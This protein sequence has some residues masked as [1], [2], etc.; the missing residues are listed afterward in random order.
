MMI[1]MKRRVL[2]V[3]AACAFL[4]TLAQATVHTM[5]VTSD[6]QYPWTDATDRGIDEDESTKRTRSEA[7]ITEQYESIAAYRA[8]RADQRIPVVINGDLTAYGHG[9][10]RDTFKRLVQ[11]LG[12]DVY[13]G[14][15]NHDYQNNIRRENGEGCF[16]NACARGS[17]QDF[18]KWMRGQRMALRVLSFDY[19][20]YPGLFRDVYQGSLGY[21]F[22][23]PG[24][25]YALQAQLHNAPNYSVRFTS[26]EGIRAAE[27][28]IEAP[29]TYWL[30]N[31][32]ADRM[33]QA[34]VSF[35]VMHMH[36]PPVY[37]AAFVET[38]RQHPVSA[39]FAGH[40][41][42]WLGLYRMIEGVPVFLS[43]SASQRSYLI[44]E[45]DDQA[46]RL[47]VY[48]V[49]NNDPEHAELAYEGEAVKSAS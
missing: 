13:L 10:Q 11:I 28:D 21:T 39:I 29:V 24:F 38:L 31:A 18:A 48:A 4:P 19:A 37:D 22:R 16:L 1:P 32:L 3:M 15:G 23:A 44:V 45:H 20:T 41:H 26:N 12:S 42:Q 8:A 36:K 5:I 6:P 47:R 35:T 17:I 30:R 25:P 43:G 27:F 7:L 40:L 34:D 33:A 46:N 14:L 49:R 9:W 2:A